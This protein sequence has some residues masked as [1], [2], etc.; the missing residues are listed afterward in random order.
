VNPPAKL[1]DLQNMPNELR[2]EYAIEYW[3]VSTQMFRYWTNN[4][5]LSIAILFR[6]LCRGYFRPFSV[7]F[8]IQ[9]TIK[10]CK[11]TERIQ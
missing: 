4:R 1:Q 5:W 10:I 7:A 11:K 6:T 8:P 3:L 9:E 2:L